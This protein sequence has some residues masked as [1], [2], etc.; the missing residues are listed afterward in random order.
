[1]F[2]HAV[3][4]VDSVV[5]FDDGDGDVDRWIDDELKLSL[6][7]IVDRQTFKQEGT[8]T[9]TGTTTEGVEQDETLETRAVVSKLTDTIEDEIDDFL[10]DGVVTTRIVVGSV[11]LSRNQLFW[12]IDLTISSSTNLINAGWF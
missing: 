9:G 10:S 7:A 1:V 5:G 8:K 3:S 12:V 2:K 4:S 6:S 11:F